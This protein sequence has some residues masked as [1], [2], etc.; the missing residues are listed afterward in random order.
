MAEPYI[1]EIRFFPYTFAPKSWASCN[2]QLL[3]INQNQALF[4]LLGT[5]YGGNGQNNFALPNLRGRFAAGAGYNNGLG[6]A[7]NLGQA[8]GSDSVTLQTSQMPSHQ[9]SGSEIAAR[10]APGN[11]GSPQGAVPSG[12]A[13]NQTAIYSSTASSETLAPFLPS[14]G[15]SQPHNNLSPYIT[16]NYCICLSGMFPSRG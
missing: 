2:G 9:H 11:L 5:T 8:G 16:I 4:A 10:S 6:L 14:V 15:G 7:F 1:A 13:M 3:P 12:E